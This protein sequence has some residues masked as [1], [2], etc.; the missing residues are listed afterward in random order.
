MAQIGVDETQVQFQSV[1][2]GVQGLCPAKTNPVSAAGKLDTL[3]IKG[4]AYE[5]EPTCRKKAYNTK[6][7]QVSSVNLTPTNSVEASGNSHAVQ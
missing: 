4:R 2:A 6:L 3:S 1:I 5:D 7:I